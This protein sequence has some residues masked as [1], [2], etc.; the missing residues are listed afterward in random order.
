[1][2]PAVTTPLPFLAERQRGL[3]VAVHADGDVLE[4]QQNLD[5]VFLQ[6]FERGVL[7]QHAVDFDFDD[8]AA[9]DRRQQHAT[10]R[11]AERVA[12][13]TLHRLDHDLRAIGADAFDVNAA[14]TQHIGG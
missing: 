6:A 4:V 5:D 12:E 13:A 1:M 8:R 7:V 2:S 11:V 14:R 10:Q 3:V 9:G